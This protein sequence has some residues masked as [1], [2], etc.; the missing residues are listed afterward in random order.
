MRTHRLALALREGSRTSIPIPLNI[1]SP[2]AGTPL[3]AVRR[4][5]PPR[6]LEVPLPVSASS[7]RER[8]SAIAGGREYNLR[9]ASAAWRFI[10]RI[11]VFVDGYLTTPGQPAAE[12]WRMIE[13]LGFEIQVDAIPIAQRST[14]APEP[15]VGLH[16]YSATLLPAVAWRPTEPATVRQTARPPKP[17]PPLRP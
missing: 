16:S 2:V 3:E 7:I 10:R 13:D 15:A 11:R 6:C 14:Q 5:T 9:S 8:N 12:V 1:L 4:L 17:W